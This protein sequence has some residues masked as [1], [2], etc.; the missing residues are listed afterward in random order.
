MPKDVPKEKMQLRRFLRTS[1]FGVDIGWLEL[2][3][4]PPFPPKK[5]RMSEGIAN[6]ELR[7]AIDKK[8]RLR[9]EGK[10]S[11]GAFELGQ[12]GGEKSHTS[13]L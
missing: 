7:M 10:R 8:L 3:S 2:R 1:F 9:G 6:C 13:G 4:W 5:L 11:Q 12:D